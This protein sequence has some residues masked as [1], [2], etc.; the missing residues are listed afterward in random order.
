[1]QLL[2]T[3]VYFL[4]MLLATEDGQL[5]VPLGVPADDGTT[6]SQDVTHPENKG[7]NWV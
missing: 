7:A 1:M 3:A 4:C 5:A 6:G 2:L